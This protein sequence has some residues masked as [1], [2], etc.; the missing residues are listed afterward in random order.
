MQIKDEITYK[1]EKGFRKLQTLLKAILLRR[2]KQT[3]INGVPIVDIPPRQQ[4]LMKAPFTPEEAS[5]YKQVETDIKEQLSKMAANGSGSQ[6][7]NMLYLLLRL[8]QACNHPWL[9]KA[10][11]AGYRRKGVKASASEMNAVLKLA[12]DRFAALLSALRAHSSQCPVCADVPEDPVV[13]SCGHVYCQQCA[14]AQLEGSS[15]GDG[16]FLCLTCNHLVRPGDVYRGAALE[17]AAADQQGGGD[18]GKGKAAAGGA[19]PSSDQQ[20]SSSTKVDK[21]LTLLDTIRQRNAGNTAAASSKAPSST[22]ASRSK[23]E[24]RMLSQ[25]RQLSAPPPAAPASKAG[26]NNRPEKVIVFSQWTSMLDLL[27]V[28]FKR[29]GFHYRRLDGT[30]TVAARERAITEFESKD[31][32]M[33]LLVS[34]KAAALGLNLTVANHVVLMDLWWNPTT[35]EQA[36]DRAHRIGQTRTVHVTRITIPG[37]VEDR[38]LAL[39]EKKRQL[40]SSALS[41]GKQGT[42]TTNRLTMDDLRFLFGG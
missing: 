39:Q 12:A 9:V 19:Q 1:P 21:L 15:T 37:T 3:T 17:T 36:I 18:G 41:D 34:L 7:I 40:V 20:W 10:G 16:E 22:L 32:V 13:T 14:A 42:G 6:Y 8:R 33:V 23:S 31:D 38:I 26:S 2:T 5:F 24:A 11:G 29:A 30:M 27:E 25:F 35:E 28:P 4:E